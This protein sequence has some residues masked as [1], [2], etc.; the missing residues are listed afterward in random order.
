MAYPIN[1]APQTPEEQEYARRMR[2]AQ[3]L[4]QDS[5]AMQGQMVSGHYIAP[6]WTQGLEKLFRGYSAGKT[7]R[8]AEQGLKDWQTQGQQS[9]DGLAKL[10]A[11]PNATDEGRNAALMAHTQRYGR[12]GID[13]YLAG[14][15]AATQ[16]KNAATA[17]ENARRKRETVEAEAKQGEVFMR[18][19][20]P[21]A[22]FVSQSGED[23]YQIIPASFDPQT[24]R[25]NEQAARDFGFDDDAMGR[26]IALAGQDPK[27]A[28]RI[29]L[30]EYKRIAKG[31]NAA[32]DVL[33]KER[34]IAEAMGMPLGQY[35]RDKQSKSGVNVTVPVNVN[36][37]GEDYR[38]TVDKEGGKY[39][40]D[41]AQQARNASTALNAI[42]EVRKYLDQ[43]MFTG[44][45]GPMKE[46]MAAWYQGITGET[47]PTLD[48]TQMARTVLGDIVLPALSNLKGAS[49]DRDFLKI[50]EYSRGEATMTESALRG[51]L[52]RLYRKYGAQIDS[53]NTT[54]GDYE[55][56]GG[57][58]IPGVRKLD[59]PK[60]QGAPMPNAA[61]PA[62]AKPAQAAPSYSFTAPNGKTYTFPDAASMAKA[63]KA[64]GI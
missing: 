16:A 28:S 22:Q 29:A 1:T 9:M 40:F 30:E 27:F 12:G 44:K 53:F 58:R 57:A 35:L 25:V 17:A 36:G 54:L 43:G 14:V 52:D 8:M 48:N 5:P 10:L 23:D 6:S 34:A 51:H 2:L 61:A 62:Q 37:L 13:T 31:K 39:L 45:L 50:E 3:A 47:L 41:E 55:A 20:F 26:I 64:M 33:A 59:K 11:D 15:N 38:K 7:E 4:R 56:Q 24:M 49:S 18:A 32:K 60:Y 46:Q 21:G 19:M 42:T 63:K